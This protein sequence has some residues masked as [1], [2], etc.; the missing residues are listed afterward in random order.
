MHRP[1]LEV[2]DI[3]H[4]DGEAWRR[5]HA[6][7]ISLGQLKVMSAIERCRTDASGGHRLHCEQCDKDR[8]AYNS[9]RNRHCPKCQGRNAEKWLQ[10][11]QGE[12]LP[13]EYYHVV[14]TLPSEIADIA[15]QNKALIYDLLFKVSAQTLLTIAADPKHLGARL[16]VTSV[17]HTWG[18]ALTHHPHV[19]CIALFPVADSTMSAGLRA[20][21]GSYC[22]CGCCRDC[23][24]ACYSSAFTK[25]TVRV[26]YSSSASSHR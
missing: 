13:V 7:H 2:A 14:F 3:L 10:A 9:C 4:R 20:S 23:S 5:A 11:R 1:P 12:L 19:H 26:N 8:I 17:L 25:H 15:Y 24:G 16:G 18:S 21:A 22:R 6:G